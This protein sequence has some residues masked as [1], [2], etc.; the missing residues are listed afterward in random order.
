MM[1]A[2]Q[3]ARRQRRLEA[4]LCALVCAGMLYITRQF[5]Q[6]CCM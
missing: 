1:R 6:L 3:R 5:L 4:L 2:S